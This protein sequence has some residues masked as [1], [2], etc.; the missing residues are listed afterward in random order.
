MTAKHGI[1]S[2][3]LVVLIII[4][5]ER[6]TPS[7]KYVI[8]STIFDGVPLPDTVFPLA[9]TDSLTAQDDSVR[10]AGR[11]AGQKPEMRVHPPFRDRQCSMCH[12]DF[13]K[14]LQKPLPALCFQC[15]EPFWNEHD[16]LHGPVISGHCIKC[17]NPHW[18]DKDKLL[19]RAGQD[20]CFECH[21]QDAILANPKHEVIGKRNCTDCHSPHGGSNN[22]MLKKGSCYNCHDIQ[23]QNEGG[24][25]HGPVAS[26]NCYECHGTHSTK[27]EHKLLRSGQD[28]CLKCHNKA[29][30]KQNVAH[31]DIGAAACT[32][33]HNPHRS[34]H[35]YMLMKSKSDEGK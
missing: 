30:I 12:Q 19:L 5:L 1:F 26:N 20:I 4:G 28:I 25:R 29:D 14:K 22:Y 13:S 34:D 31:R 2:F 11:L 17:H 16:K 7:K 10:I 24:F 35:K 3:L 32:S 9:F 6:C 33:C 23:M 27:T 18:T 21:K 15:H 8:L